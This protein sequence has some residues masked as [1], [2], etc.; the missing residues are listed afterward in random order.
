MFALNNHS[1]TNKHSRKARISIDFIGVSDRRVAVDSSVIM[2]LHYRLI[3][4]ISVSSGRSPSI[5]SHHVLFSG[6]LRTFRCMAR[7]R[8]YVLCPLKSRMDLWRVYLMFISYTKRDQPTRTLLSVDAALLVVPRC[9]LRIHS[10]PT[11]RRRR[12]LFI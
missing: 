7:Q 3:S 4:S 9:N 8:S 11:C 1:C 12:M 2:L 5:D 6:P 10:I